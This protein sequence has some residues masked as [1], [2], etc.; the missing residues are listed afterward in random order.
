LQNTGSPVASSLES[1]RQPI[2]IKKTLV[3]TSYLYLAFSFFLRS[4][5]LSALRLAGAEKIFD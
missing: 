3:S 5:S 2:L 4:F 1:F